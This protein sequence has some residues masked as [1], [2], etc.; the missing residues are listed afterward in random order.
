MLRRPSPLTH[1]FAYLFRSLI[2]V[3]LTDEDFAT[4]ECEG[5]HTSWEGDVVEGLC[6]ARIDREARF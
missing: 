5:V 4:R 3:R 1:Q 2:A 6:G